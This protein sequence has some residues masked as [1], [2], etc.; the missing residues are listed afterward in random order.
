MKFTLKWLKQFLATNANLTDITQALTNLGLEVESIIDRSVELK[1]FIIAEIIDVKPHP[2]ATKL[3]ICEVNSGKKILQ[4]VCGASNARTGLKVVLAIP[5]TK[6]PNGDF[7]IKTTNIRG[8]TSQGM[9]C[10][11]KELLISNSNNNCIIELP[12]TAIV[13]NSFAED[14]G[15]D[16]SVIQINV[17]P[18]R[19]DCLGVYGIARELQAKGLGKLVENSFHKIHNT[20]FQSNIKLHVSAKDACPLF[21]A[22]EVQNINTACSSPLWLQHFLH[23]IG[24]KSISPT[25]DVTNYVCYSFGYPIHAYDKDKLLNNEI[26]IRTAYANENI[27]ALNNQTYK[28]TPKDLVVSCGS[29]IIALAGIIGG[30]NSSCNSKTNNIILETGYFVPNKIITTGRRLNI[31]SDARHR[32]E[33]HVDYS[34]ASKVHTIALNLITSICGGEISE[35]I[36]FDNISITPAKILEFP[37]N[38]FEKK[39]GIKLETSTIINILVNLGFTICNAT[40]ST[41]KIKIPSWRSDIAIKE[42]IVEELLRVSGYDL[43]PEIPIKSNQQSCIVLPN[44]QQKISTLK[45]VTAT[46]GY[47]EVVTWSFISSKIV[48]Y[49]STY[50]EKLKIL[51]PISQELDYMRP[52][53]IPNLLESIAKNQARSIK[54]QAFF[55]V[56]PVFSE[57]KIGQEQCVLAA[58]KCGNK[59]LIHPHNQIL[60]WD[61]FDIKADLENILFELGINIENCKIITNATRQYYHPGRFGSIMLSNTCIG[62]FGEI[63]PEILANVNIN[64]RV[65]ALELNIDSL[66]IK[67]SQPKKQIILSN[68][69]HIERDFAF[70][71]DKFIPALE[72]AASIK[73]VNKNLIKK[74]EVFD[75]Y[76]GE[77]IDNNKKSLAFRVTIQSNEQTLTELIIKE[78]SSNIISTIE[79]AFDAILRDH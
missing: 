3:Q 70:I 46:C 76:S 42:D 41:L 27:T 47:N 16:D 10:S 18:N 51:N 14:F 45:K 74:V 12:N 55:E 63:H 38:E 22:T 33:R 11:E 75:V 67:K 79:K 24:L 64:N 56:G 68:Y 15:Y 4:I 37:I 28:L 36:V 60:E 23:N 52:T 43:L 72:I 1:D 57:K 78:I 49:F 13:G 39:T 66:Q 26:E 58:V 20:H 17:T 7:I 2:N 40:S 32:F 29:K 62:C 9:L 77:K 69:P 54:N 44:K 59:E 34:I 5:G 61:I 6:I 73:E 30:L 19:G 25:I 21:I 53:I 8:I 50:N 31:E 65:M 71:V 48:K 35:T